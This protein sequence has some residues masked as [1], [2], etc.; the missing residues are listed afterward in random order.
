MNLKE[1][2]DSRR[3]MREYTAAAVEEQTIRD[4]I[5]AAIMAPSAVN[6]QPWTFTVVRDRSVLDRF[7]SQAKALMLASPD[8]SRDHHS[9]H[10]ASVLGDPEFNI[11]YQAPVLIV[12]SAALAGPWAVVDCTLAAENLMLAAHGAGLGSCWIGFAQAYLNTDAGK[13]LLGMPAAWLPVAPIIIG[14]PKG[15]APAVPR[16]E[17]VIHWK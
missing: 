14:H 8:F 17:P 2:L 4:L 10:F 12:I 9:G 3:A 6:E 13:E 1:A 5:G 7:S 15:V 11:F 16:K